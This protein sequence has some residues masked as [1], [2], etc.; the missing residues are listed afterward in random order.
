MKHALWL[1]ALVVWAIG[2][3]AVLAGTRTITVTGTVD[4]PQAVVTVNGTAA[5]VSGG[6]FSASVTLTEGNNTITATATDPAGNSASAS[7][8]V[9]LDT[10]PPVITI[11]FP[12]N[13]Q[14]IGSGN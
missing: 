1:V 14:V 13:G 3:P 9:S 12:A 10:V 5:T 2:G 6:N 4:D 7:V 11:S 8:T